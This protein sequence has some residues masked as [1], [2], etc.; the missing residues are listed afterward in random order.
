MSDDLTPQT[1]PPEN[2][3]QLSDDELIERLHDHRQGT[4]EWAAVLGEIQRRSDRQSSD[5]RFKAALASADDD[6]E[7]SA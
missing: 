2:P 6:L 3:A 4:G 5:A 1:P 7:P